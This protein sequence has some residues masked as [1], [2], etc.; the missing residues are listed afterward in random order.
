MGMKGGIIFTLTS[1]LIVFIF[2]FDVKVSAIVRKIPILSSVIDTKMLEEFEA[3]NEQDEFYQAIMKDAD[4]EEY[5]SEPDTAPNTTSGKVLSPDVL[6][7][8][9]PFKDAPVP[10]AIKN[11][12]PAKAKIENMAVRNISAT[13]KLFRVTLD[14]GMVRYIQVRKEGG[15]YVISG[16]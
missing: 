9:M 8:A 14:N 4:G 6:P 7:S 10:K 16:E 2:V 3:I 5:K 1:L 12:L 13:E 15:K 11:L